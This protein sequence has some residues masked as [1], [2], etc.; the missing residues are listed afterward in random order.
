MHILSIC[1]CVCLCVCVC[2]C[3]YVCVCVCVGGVFAVTGCN[4]VI[5]TLVTGTGLATYGISN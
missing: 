3:L 4:T 1:V 2:V 5:V